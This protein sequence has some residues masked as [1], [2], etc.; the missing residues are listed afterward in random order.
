MVERDTESAA[1]PWTSAD[2][3]IPGLFVGSFAAAQKLEHLKEQGITHIVNCSRELP[4]Y[5]SGKFEYLHVKLTDNTTQNIICAFPAVI[6]FIHQARNSGGVILVHCASGSSRSGTIAI[7]YLLALEGKGL[8]ETI[9]IVQKQRSQV[10][11]NPGFLKQL[12]YFHRM[13][14]HLPDNGL[15]EP[16]N[17][18][19]KN[20]IVK[21]LGLFGSLP[22]IKHIPKRSTS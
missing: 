4:L 3:I 8:D 12:S 19:E 22:E 10:C 20:K 2:Y 11:P 16:F 5:H 6:N 7:A 13:K 9:E 15:L 18:E 17:K 21:D 1:L 14:R